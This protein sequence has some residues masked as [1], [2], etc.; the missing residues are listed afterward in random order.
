MNQVR[1]INR[2]SAPSVFLTALFLSV[3]LS[4]PSCATA[5]LPG[6][7]AA[8]LQPLPEDRARGAV[9]G[10][11]GGQRADEPESE[12]EP[13]ELP[14]H[15]H[16]LMG[17]GLSVVQLDP[18]GIDPQALSELVD[19]P[20]G[21][22]R[23]ILTLTDQAIGFFVPRGR[24]F[25]PSGAVLYVSLGVPSQIL[26][27]RVLEMGFVSKPVFIGNT[28]RPRWV[29]ESDENPPFHLELIEAG[30]YMLTL[31]AD[32][33]FGREILSGLRAVA[34]TQR[35]GSGA[36]WERKGPVHSEERETPP[37]FAV[38]GGMSSDFLGP[39]GGDLS[40]IGELRFSLS[41]GDDGVFLADAVME[42]SSSFQARALRLLLRVAFLQVLR[43][44]FPLEDAAVLRE[45]VDIRIEGS[46]IHVYRLPLRAAWIREA[47]FS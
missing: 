33:A 13:V 30:L 17:R 21:L 6:L 39:L 42:A 35:R 15:I 24:Q 22:S 12:P 8:G 37:A 28:R 46:R 18:R 16:E 9:D 4:L 11:D 1:R 38:G 26:E 44:N 10:M 41:A 14:V 3:V 40:G 7:D 36:S 32:P 29:L 34:Q 2:I 43:Q 20:P 19:L 31:G 25:S 27:P 23:I 47:F 45:L 5:A